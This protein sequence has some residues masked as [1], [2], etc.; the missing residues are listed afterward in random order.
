LLKKVL[1]GMARSAATLLLPWASSRAS[2]S[3]DVHRRGTR[4]PSLR[5]ARRGV[6]TANPATAGP[7]EDRKPWPATSA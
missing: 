3:V 4:H 6:G 5:R 1:L 2:M 7:A